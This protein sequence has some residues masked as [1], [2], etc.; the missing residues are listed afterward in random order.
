MESLMRCAV[1]RS[2]LP[3]LAVGFLSDVEAFAVRR[4]IASCDE[5][6]AEAQS[7]LGMIEG[8]VQ[9]SGSERVSEPVNPDAFER[10]IWKNSEVK[11][12]PLRRPRR[13]VVTGLRFRLA[14]I[15]IF[16]FCGWYFTSIISMPHH[17]PETDTG[18]REL[19]HVP[20][21]AQVVSPPGFRPVAAD[22]FIYMIKKEGD[23]SKIIAYD[24]ASGT[25]RWIVS[26]TFNGNLSVAGSKLYA[27]E[28]S[29][30][31]NEY[32]LHAFDATTGTDRWHCRRFRNE[33]TWSTG[34]TEATPEHVVW[35]SGTELL[36]LDPETGTRMWSRIIP[37]NVVAPCI[38]LIGTRLYT[39]T[40]DSVRIGDVT[41][42]NVLR[43]VAFKER[44]SGLWT[45]LLATD[46]ER[47]FVGHRTIDNNASVYCFDADGI[48]R[49]HSPMPRF[50]SMDHADATL[51][52]RSQA[53]YAL[54]ARSGIIKWKV[55]A[56]GCSPTANSC[57]YCFVAAGGDDSTLL[58]LNLFSGKI[59]NRYPIGGSCNGLVLDR[60]TGYLLDNK[61]ILHALDLRRFIGCGTTGT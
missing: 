1:C 33:N 11:R 58:Q 16:C 29:L 37:G 6:N 57:G 5:C 21:V 44:M 26:G 13:S 18:M 30:T 51:L 59:I 15:V 55:D 7:Y 45:P 39:V 48:L 50:T 32:I 17:R 54:D 24:A 53:V 46:G 56:G 3:L 4:H 36:S 8:L 23:S 2:K 61:G 12:V 49:W 43:T 14:A 34:F 52:C 40:A 9:S 38:K 60:G 35:M 25:E 42:G 41:T 28:Y 27:T 47:L 19:W 20:A 22:G 10:A 31:D